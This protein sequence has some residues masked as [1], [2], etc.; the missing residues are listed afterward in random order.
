[1]RW[2]FLFFL[3][4]S[5]FASLTKKVPNSP[6]I[7]E[8]ETRLDATFQVEIEDFEKLEHQHQL[9]LSKTVTENAEDYLLFHNK[10]YI[11]V[12]DTKHGRVHSVFATV[13]NFRDISL[14]TFDKIQVQLHKD[15]S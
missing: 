5:F 6:W 9:I 1:M 10:E 11:S 7:R 14:R 13:S 2:K 4:S 15:L 3:I 8:A 12:Y